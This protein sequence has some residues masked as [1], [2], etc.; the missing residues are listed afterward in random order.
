MG[1]CVDLLRDAVLAAEVR[2][3]LL[4]QHAQNHDTRALHAKLDELILTL[5]GP[6]DEIAR[7]EERA[8]DELEELRGEPDL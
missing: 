4:L 6:R 7:I 2:Q 3:D 1:C 8:A 5:D